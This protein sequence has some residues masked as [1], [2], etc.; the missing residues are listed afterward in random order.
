[1]P[2]LVITFKVEEL[3]NKRRFDEATELLDYA[4]KIN[5]KDTNSLFRKA[6][7]SV[8]LGDLET[9]VVYYEKAQEILPNEGV[10]N[11]RLQAVKKQIAGSAA[12]RVE[13]AINSL[14][15]EQGIKVY[16]E[17]NKQ[18]PEGIYFDEREFNTL[19]YRL[20]S[21][22]LTD[23]ALEVFKM[24]TE[25]YPASANAFDSLAEAYMAKGDKELSLKNYKKSLELNPKNENAEKKIKELEK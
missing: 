23:A 25:L 2:S 12:Y 10:I 21:K 24:N 13:K 19:G 6:M 4:L 1:M 14:G 20:L 17:I 15:V 9:A 3:I 8:S 11:L 7:L 16:N 22:G 5:P 18:K